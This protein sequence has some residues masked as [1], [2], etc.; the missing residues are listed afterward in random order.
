MTIATSSRPRASSSAQR[1]TDTRVPM[2]SIASPTQPA[3]A[4]TAA[5][6]SQTP[7]SAASA[8]PPRCRAASERRILRGTDSSRSKSVGTVITLVVLALIVFWVIGMYNN[9][10]SSRNRVRNAFSQIDVQL[11]RR[12]DLI[13]NLVE[14][15]KGYM[16]HER[17]TLEA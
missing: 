2:R 15:V 13:P 4:G 14:A 10:V 1:S 9:L 8:P 6:A 7:A 12:Y 17:G 16:S 3:D 11:T 5:D